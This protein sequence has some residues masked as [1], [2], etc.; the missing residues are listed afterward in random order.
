MLPSVYKAALCLQR[1][2]SPGAE[3]CSSPRVAPAGTLPRVAEPRSNSPVF[4]IL[5]PGVPRPPPH[6]G[7]GVRGRSWEQQQAS[8]GTPAAL[9]RPAAMGWLEEPNWQ[10]HVSL[11]ML[12]S[13][14]TRGKRT[15]YC[16][17]AASLSVHLAFLLPVTAHSG[18][19][20]PGG[21]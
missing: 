18:Y 20:G 21:F 1:R 10:L 2:A 3:Q 17:R 14:H 11:L 16:L 6:E 15:V 19:L 5:L 13:L 12:L 8:P 4:P 7:L 9:H